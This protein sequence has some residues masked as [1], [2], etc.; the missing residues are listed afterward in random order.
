MN[1]SLQRVV[2][3]HNLIARGADYCALWRT[4]AGWLL[5]GTAIA[6]PKESAA[7]LTRYEVHCDDRWRT[8]FVEVEVTLGDQTRALQLTV[9]NGGKWL[10]QCELTELA[11]CVDVDLAIT[12]ATNTLPIRRLSIPV[13]ES[14]DV[15]AAWIKFPD[16]AAEPL[17]QRYTRLSA[18]TYRYQTNSGFV[19]EIVMDELGLVISYKDA[20]ERLDR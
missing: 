20:W 13:G 10:A 6:V 7:M 19:S 17:Q 15:T 16:L 1:D 18:D 9:E 12:P 2:T 11:G 3:W 5:K 8:H 14:R 4:R